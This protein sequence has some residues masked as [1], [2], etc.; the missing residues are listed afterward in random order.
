MSECFNSWIREDRD[1]PILQLLENFRRKIMVR[2]CKK[3]A[4]ADKSNDIITPYAR[5]NLTVNEKE[6]RKL[7]VIHG[8]GRWYETIDQG[9]VKF[10]VNTDDATCDCGMWQMT[11]LPCKHAIALL[12]Y[13]REHAHH[14]VH[15]YYSKQAWKM[16]YDG[17]INPIPDESR[18]PKF[19]SQ[20][21]EPPVQKTKAGRP[22]KKRTRETD[23]P[24]A[25]NATFSKRC[26]LCGVLGHNWATCP[27]KVAVLLLASLPLVYESSYCG[28]H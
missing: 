3:W 2:F 6:A 9:G 14:R 25:P 18:W 17:T 19:E 8:R 21:V 7:Q 16:A 12:M 13:N 20:T 10:L 26:S 24:R 23:E 15:W 5:E 28:P 1:K 27:S 11:G 4:E 22:K